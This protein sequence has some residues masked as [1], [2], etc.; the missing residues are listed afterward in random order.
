MLKLMNS[1]INSPQKPQAEGETEGG[2]HVKLELEDEE[3]QEADSA[4]RRHG[5]ILYVIFCHITAVP[6]S[7]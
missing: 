4:G 6:M 5:G 3:A 1:N 7:P 2:D